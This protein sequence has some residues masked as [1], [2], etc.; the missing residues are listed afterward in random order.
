MFYRLEY[1][2]TVDSHWR[3]L[4]TMECSLEVAKQELEYQTRSYNYKISRLFHLP[5]CLR[6]LE[7]K[8]ITHSS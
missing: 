6:L 3:E 4:S 5:N 7:C 2:R 8:E 1:R